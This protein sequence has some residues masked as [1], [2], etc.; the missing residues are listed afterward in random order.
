MYTVAP[1]GPY[2]VRMAVCA[3]SAS[4]TAMNGGGA[5]SRRAGENTETSRNQLGLDAEDREGTAH[6]SVYTPPPTSYVDRPSAPT[7][8]KTG[9]TPGTVSASPGTYTSWAWAERPQGGHRQ[10]RYNVS[11]VLPVSLIWRSHCSPYEATAA[12]EMR[13]TELRRRDIALGVGWFDLSGWSEWR[14]GCSEGCLCVY[15]L[16]V[17]QSNEIQN[18]R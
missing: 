11:Y 18:W 5:R 14:N 7:P 4:W 8:I 6:G 10:R 1:A 17:G 13:R 16:Y 3:F 15:I 2:C 9:V 12:S